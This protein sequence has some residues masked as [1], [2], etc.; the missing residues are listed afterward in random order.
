M[1]V[2]GR[3]SGELAMSEKFQNKYRIQTARLRNWDYSSNAMYFVTICTKDRNHYFGKITGN[4]DATCCVSLTEIGKTANQCWH[5]IPDHF[6][7]V[8]LDA[9][10]IMPDHMHGII[11]IDKPDETGT[12]GPHTPNKFGPQLKNLASIVRGFKIGVTKYAR[13][14][15]IAFAWQPRYYDHIIRDKK[16]F[17]NITNCISENLLKWNHEEYY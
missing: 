16:S 14:N 4:N 1:G 9:F 5:D 7:F 15:D 3:N 17:K 13:N 12:T 6:P 8:K 11:I 10:V 2:T